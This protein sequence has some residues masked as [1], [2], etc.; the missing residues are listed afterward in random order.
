[1][2]SMDLNNR[3]VNR[4]NYKMYVCECM[5]VIEIGNNRENG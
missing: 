2:D 5:N 3:R 4:G 1:M